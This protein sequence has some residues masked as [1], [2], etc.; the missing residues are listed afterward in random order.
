MIAEIRFKVG[1]E[2][3]EN[4]RSVREQKKKNNL[5][6]PCLDEDVFKQGL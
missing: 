1:I 3:R 6:Q 5:L 4:K 2:K